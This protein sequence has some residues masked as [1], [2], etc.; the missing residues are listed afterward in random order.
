MKKNIIYIIPGMGENCNLLRYRKMSRL[1]FEKGYEVKEVNPDWYKPISGQIFKIEKDSIIF[2]FSAGAILAYLV[3]NKYKCKKVILAS[4]TPVKII[5]QK[6]IYDILIE[7]MSE[8]LSLEI[9]KDYKKIKVNLEKLKTPYI[10]ITGGK[11]ILL[12]GESVSDF[13]IPKATHRISG[14]YLAALLKIL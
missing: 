12:R 3:V 11:E 2:G 4:M 5:S 8:K 6:E 9:S 14:S 10:T 7:K 1:L 13:I